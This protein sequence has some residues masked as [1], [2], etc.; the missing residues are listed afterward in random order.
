MTKQRLAYVSWFGIFFFALGLVWLSVIYR[1]VEPFLPGAHRDARPASV[2]QDYRTLPEE[3]S[4]TLQRTT[5]ID[6]VVA[7]QGD[8]PSSHKPYV[9]QFW[10]LAVVELLCCFVYVFC[11]V[12]VLRGYPFARW[13]VLVTGYLDFVYKMMVVVYM[14]Q[15]AIPIQRGIGQN[16]LGGYYAP[17]MRLDSQIS[18]YLSGLKAYQPDGAIYVFIYLSYLFLVFYVFTRAEVKNHFE[19][20]EV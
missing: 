19:K 14:E 18:L 8:T 3:M 13:G 5:A 2:V 1:R 9:T 12:A 20:G 10:G 6:R 11:G 4:E 16:I 15:W 7:A 17:D